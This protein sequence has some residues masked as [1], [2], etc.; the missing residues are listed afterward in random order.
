MSPINTT[1][2]FN[3]KSGAWEIVISGFEAHRM[4]RMF[5]DAAMKL[6]MSLW[7][8]VVKK[9]T[10]VIEELKPFAS[11]NPREAIAD[12]S[13]SSDAVEYLSACSPT[14]DEDSKVGDYC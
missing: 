12:G 5:S 2:K 1:I 11:L 7:P 13:L 8:D 10:S 9:P 14:F 4:A 6:P 3:S